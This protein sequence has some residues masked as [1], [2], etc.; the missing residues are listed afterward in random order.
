[1]KNKRRGLFLFSL[2]EKDYLKDM[3]DKIELVSCLNG[4][5]YCQTHLEVINKRFSSSNQYILNKDYYRSIESL[6]SAYE[7]TAELS[8]SSCS[9]CAELFRETI[10]KSLENIQGD[11]L[12]MSNGFLKPKRFQVSYRLATSTLEE[13]KRK[14]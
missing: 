1:M 2:K 12:K 3:E 9:Q 8:E 11:L 10:T 14:P 7:E 5:K 13:L 4:G 6:K